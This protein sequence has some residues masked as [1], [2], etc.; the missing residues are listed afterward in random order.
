[1]KSSFLIKFIL[2][3]LLIQ[4]VA[5]FPFASK[6]FGQHRNYE[7][8][9]E[10]NGFKGKTVHD[11]ER[12]ENGDFWLGT[13]KGVV[14][15]DGVNFIDIHNKQLKDSPVDKLYL[16]K[17]NLYIIYKKGGCDLLDLNNYKVSK[18]TDALIV[19]L[20]FLN[21]KLYLIQSNG[22]LFS[23]QSGVKKQLYKSTVY[24]DRS[25][26]STWKN[27]LIIGVPGNGIYVNTPSHDNVFEKIMSDSQ[28]VK[29]ELNPI[30]D[31]LF[32]AV[33]HSVYS[34]DKNL[35]ARLLLHGYSK[36]GFDF[37]DE[38]AFYSDSL[39]FY[40]L[41]TKYLYRIK[42]GKH[43]EI[44]FDKL[45]NVALYKM[46][47][48]DPKNLVVGTN[49]G[50]VIFKE[51]DSINAEIDD[52]YYTA[53]NYI[54]IR[55]KIIPW[56]NDRSI[57]LGNPYIYEYGPNR[58]FRKVTNHLFASYDGLI[59]KN[60]LFLCSEGQGP[61]IVDLNTGNCTILKQFPFSLFNRTYSILYDSVH[62]SVV[63][64]G[65]SAIGIYQV[66]THQ[67]KTIPIF[68]N[69]SVINN[70]ILEPSLK[71]YW[72]STDKSLFVLDSNFKF[73]KDFSLKTSAWKLNNIGDLK[74][75][76][77]TGLIWIA[78]ENGALV[79]NPRTCRIQL[80]LTGSEF[81]NPRLVAILEDRKGRMWMSS[82]EGIFGYDTNTKE[83]I[84][85]VRKNNL[86]NSEYNYKS[87]AVLQNG[88][89]IFGGLNGYDIIN[90][91]YFDF[92]V[93][94]KKG[95]ISGYEIISSTDTSFHFSNK[96]EETEINFNTTNEIVT[97]FLSVEKE[98]LAGRYSYEYSYD[99]DRWIKIID[100]AKISINKLLPNSYLLSIRAFDEFGRLIKFN[101]IRINA[102]VDF[103]KSRTFLILAFTCIFILMI[104][105]LRVNIKRNQQEKY[106]REKISMDLHDEVGTL[107]TRALYLSEE[108]HELKKNKLITN[109][110]KESLYSL[111]LYINTI[112]KTQMD[113]K[114]LTTH[115]MEMS[116][117]MLDP[118]EYSFYT[119]INQDEEIMITGE[120]Y[121]DI[122][123][124]IYEVFNNLKKYAAAEKI[125][126]SIQRI[127]N[128]L[129]IQIEDDGAL[130]S[131][132]KLENK[133]RGIT[134]L[135]KRTTRHLGEALFSVSDAGHGLKINLIFHIILFL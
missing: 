15:Y 70:I 112:N 123:L 8:F 23:M 32:V 133:G 20:V 41:N 83:W 118:I 78:H 12:D 54:N 59:L 55:R 44:Q 34:I 110:L 103:L 72:V 113:L 91:D 66:N 130:S 105:L 9:N 76:K 42:N 98:T 36:D 134:N 86:I 77:S 46:Y 96:N 73:L 2:F 22:L 127:Q 39:Q 128:K 53:T 33:D 74:I 94:E 99:G 17:N 102:R 7:L 81:P 10:T 120:L 13:E 31:S 129:V 43:E 67:T 35:K 60:Q 57:L 111:R 122:E 93:I 37:K 47:A 79:I 11:I 90:P 131:V 3:Q 62:Q 5:L 92:Q 106:I 75:Q 4:I 61:A 19:D 68:T 58:S 48:K 126:I 108:E 16:Y 109:Y 117:S 56:K 30:K 88:R 45:K 104:L 119:N 27:K 82:Y 114:M 65:N 1:M 25:V 95:K 80:E 28:G 29:I 84:K 21:D 63:F 26:L 69:N 51:E 132:A 89:L 64:G 121:R 6:S 14:L 97:I 116:G 50:L 40:F 135:R 125:Q 100:P 49:Q 52:N 85:L 71:Q 115:I 38:F 87:A 107:L 124:C 24:N 101:P 18:I